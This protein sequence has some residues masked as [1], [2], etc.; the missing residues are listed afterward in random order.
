MCGHGGVTFP[1]SWRRSSL[2]TINWYRGERVGGL[3]NTGIAE[4]KREVHIH[5]QQKHSNNIIYIVII[6]IIISKTQRK[7]SQV[8]LAIL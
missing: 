2:W 8:A 5:Y 1:S 6:I 3:S 7:H 4:K